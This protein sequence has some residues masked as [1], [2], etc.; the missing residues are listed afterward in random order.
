MHQA[1]DRRLT[2]AAFQCRL[3]DRV[4]DLTPA[5]LMSELYLDPL[6]GAYNRR[7]LAA[8][9]SECL[10]IIDCD[11]LKWVN[12]HQGH[13]AGDALLVKLADALQVE[14]GRASVFRLGGDEFVVRCH[15]SAVLHNR[16][17]R[18][19]R[20]MF[21]GFSFGIGVTLP[22]ADRDLRDE[23]GRRERG[24]L[25]ASRGDAPPVTFGLLAPVAAAR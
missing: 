18:V 11:S 12:D 21:P 1:T 19:R 6:T 25:R 8:A 4:R 24:G 9:T 15:D 14:F 16:L 13:C 20:L 3:R 5:Q 17:D 22:E 2:A 7:A 10:A 23:K